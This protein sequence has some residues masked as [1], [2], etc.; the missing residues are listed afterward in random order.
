[1]WMLLLT[2]AWGNAVAFFQTPFG[3]MVL[4]VIV[5]FIY[6]ISLYGCGHHNGVAKE[7]AKWT[8]VAAQAKIASSAGAKL[9]ADARKANDTA[10]QA[11][12][13]KVV[14]LT[15]EVPRYVTA[16]ADANCVVSAGFVRMH[17][18]DVGPASGTASGHNQGGPGMEGV[19]APSGVKLSDV[20]A[21]DLVNHGNF[22]SLR[23]E[24]LAWRSFYPKLQA[25]WQ[26]KAS[27]GAD[28]PH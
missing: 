3:R 28:P 27:S 8:A 19:D 11:I 10:Q 26:S 6:S 18:A 1:M 9:S 5:F 24:V 4:L 25:L 12:T 15:K 21:T 7:R 17:D 14:Y 16:K 13:E 2:K 22:E 23:S 20:A